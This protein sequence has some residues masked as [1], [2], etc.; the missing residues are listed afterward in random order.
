MHDTWKISRLGCS[1]AKR[2]VKKRGS[3]QSQLFIARDFSRHIFDIIKKCWTAKDTRSPTYCSCPLQNRESCPAPMPIAQCQLR[4]P[5]HRLIWPCTWAQ[6]K[7]R[8]EH[9]LQWSTWSYSQFPAPFQGHC[10]KIALKITTSEQTMS[11]AHPLQRKLQGQ[12]VGGT[13]GVKTSTMIHNGLANTAQQSEG[14]TRTCRAAGN[15]I[16]WKDLICQTVF[17][18]EHP[19]FL[20]F[21]CLFQTL[22]SI[23]WGNASPLNIFKSLNMLWL[24]VFLGTLRHLYF[25]RFFPCLDIVHMCLA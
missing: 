25:H 2:A 20:A 22:S 8:A 14:K 3:S 19:W 7:P 10:F 16:Y 4:K 21:S 5:M 13:A 1:I 15:S 12:M 18:Q 24:V 17:A 11:G 9:P 6:H 23:S